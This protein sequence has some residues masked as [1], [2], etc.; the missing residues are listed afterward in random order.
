MLGILI[1]NWKNGYSR[2]Q[3]GNQDF[4]FTIN[5]QI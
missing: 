1:E 5:Y 2:D 4:K 3:I